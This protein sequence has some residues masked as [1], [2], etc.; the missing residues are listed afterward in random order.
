MEQEIIAEQLRV[1]EQY[2]A[3]IKTNDISVI[4]LSK[5]IQ[6]SDKVNVI[7]LPGPVDSNC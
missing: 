3:S 1:Y 6:T 7:R 2:D 4:R 5:P